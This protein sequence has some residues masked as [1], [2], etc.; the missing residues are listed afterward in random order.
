MEAM[1]PSSVAANNGTS[2]TS[3]E[4]EDYASSKSHLS[5]PPQEE[6]QAVALN[7]NNKMQ[8]S[9]GVNYQRNGGNLAATM[10]TPS[11]WTLPGNY[12]MPSMV[13]QNSFMKYAMV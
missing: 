8:V 7:E 3:N 1:K 12:S 10:V 9:Q 5:A 4:D 6:G 13:P 11:S 2:S